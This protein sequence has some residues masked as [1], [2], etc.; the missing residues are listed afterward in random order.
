MQQEVTLEFLGFEEKFAAV[1][2][3]VHKGN[4]D[5]KKE[6]L[7][8][9]FYKLGSNAFQVVGNQQRYIWPNLM[10]FLGSMN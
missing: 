2:V 9:G 1:R 7:S 4:T 10:L 3:D 8:L 6:L 5:V